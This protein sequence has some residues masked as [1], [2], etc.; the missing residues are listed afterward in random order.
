MEHR[1]KITL[2]SNTYILYDHHTKT[3]THWEE[4]TGAYLERPLTRAQAQELINSNLMHTAK[5]ED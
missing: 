4:F 3:Y 5:R 2:T 1:T